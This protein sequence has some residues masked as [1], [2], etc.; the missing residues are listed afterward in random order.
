MRKEI[1]ETLQ[2]KLT[3][4]WTSTNYPGISC[5]PHSVRVSWRK[6]AVTDDDDDDD[7]DVDDNVD[8]HHPLK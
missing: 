8:D 6:V 2:R 4:D 5:L 3:D 7:D 1:I